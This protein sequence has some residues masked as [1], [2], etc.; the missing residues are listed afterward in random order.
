MAQALVFTLAAPLASFGAVAVGERRPTWDRPG[1]SQIIGLLACAL[2]I[3]RADEARQSDLA[4]GLRLAIRVDDPGHLASDYHTT[5]VPP[6]RRNRTFAT[7]A[8]ELDVPKHELK[9]ILSR[10]EFRVGSRYTLAVWYDPARA[11]TLE[12]FR[13]KLEQPEFILFAGRKAFPLMLPTHP[14][15]VA[16]SGGIE[17]VFSNYDGA[18]SEDMRSMIASITSRRRRTPQIFIDAD[19]VP[20]SQLVNRIEERRDIPESRE[21]WR[22]GLRS[23]ALLRQTRANE[24]PAS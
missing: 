22:F 3:E 13:S 4:N 1:K 21:K 23:E 19:A 20:G 7:R 8:E 24:E 15:I 9:T 14:Q 17:A 12:L 16:L 2:G 10:R 5:Q 18:L 6:Q 11:D